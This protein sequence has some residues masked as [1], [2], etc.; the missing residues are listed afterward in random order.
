LNTANSVILC[1]DDEPGNLKLLER[2]LSPSGYLV[3]KANDGQEALDIIAS[4]K[5]DLVLT[6][7][8][9]PGIN[10]FETCRRIKED[11]QYRHIPVVMITAL[12]SKEDRI[13]GIEAGV[14]DFLA[15]PFDHAEVLARVK[16]L[17]K[18]RQ[19]DEM[20]DDSYRN[21]QH[22][23]SF[24]S[25]IMTTFRP[26]EFNLMAQIDSLADQII[27]KDTGDTGKPSTMLVRM[28]NN[29]MLSW[30]LYTHK[31]GKLERSE[32]YLNVPLSNSGEGATYYNNPGSL[33]KFRQLLEAL[34][35][36]G[37]EAS[38]MVCLLSN[39]VSIFTLN[40]GR[41]VTRFDAAVLE[42]L[43]MQTLFFMQLATQIRAS[44]DAFSYTVHALARAAEANDEDTGAHILRVGKYCTILAKKLCLPEEFV[45]S[46]ELQAVLHD[47]GK[48]HIPSEILKKSG[49]L[50][51]KEWEIM[52]LHTVKGAKIIGDHPEFR[53]AKQIAL[54]HHER[55]DGSGY[56]FGY[57]GERIPLEGRIMSIADQY[58]AL[59]NSRV[60]KPALDHDTTVKILTEGDGRTMPQHFDPQVLQAFVDTAH[61]CAEV[62]DSFSED[63]GALNHSGAGFRNFIYEAKLTDT[64][65]ILIIDDDPRLRKTLSDILSANGYKTIVAP[66]GEEGLFLLKNCRTN[67]VLID[68]GLPDMPGIE[69]LGRIKDGHPF[70][71][72][73]ILT[74]NAT[75]E[76]A[77]ESTNSGA[78]SYLLKPYD[79]E[80]LL[81]HIKRAI[82]KQQAEATF[83][84]HS[85]KLEKVNAELK[86]LY[87]VSTVVSKSIDINGILSEILQVLSKLEIYR[88]VNK[89]ALF[90][91]ENKTLRLVSSVNFPAAA[92]EQCKS[93][94][95]GE[96]L[97]GQAES[98]REII[99]SPNDASSSPQTI[100][101]PE[102]TLHRQI[103]IPLKADDKVLGVINLYIEHASRIDEQV[104]NMFSTMGS[105]IGVALEK[106]ILY[107]ETKISSLHDPLTGLGNRRAL[108]LH[109]EKGFAVAKRYEESFSVVM[110]DIDRFKRFNDIHGHQAGDKLLVKVAEILSLETRSS[111][112]VFRYGGEEFL[113]ILA[114]T[115]LANARMVAEKLRGNVE[116]KAG[117]TISLGVAT[118]DESMVN[119]EE[120]VRFAD[121]ALYRAKEKGRNRVE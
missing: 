14:D 73:I 43:A 94:K 61:L 117:I 89:G 86:T 60:Y 100:C 96:C 108:E 92:L 54:S 91:V 103:I 65:S 71:E 31:S 7:V 81:L 116:A 52:K 85:R 114:R 74:G 51:L 102:S 45:N 2:T 13:R 97:C 29:D 34:G 67:V 113:I 99:Y 55:W 93:I 17:L 37:V 49:D 107:E 88:I 84:E 78:F 27:R 62:Y 12:G 109:L 70:V 42:G 35:T 24:G 110:V 30:Y 25:Q 104:R 15:K 36:L 77:I 120:L 9:M 80:Q 112:C 44:D 66:D 40:Y 53:V 115:D 18:T 26:A 33:P 22:L 119:S 69:L 47:V 72:A 90:L 68:L 20:L 21:I 64:P 39:T 32:S 6:D 118:Y 10:G 16:M 3:I 79:I 63:S 111:D 76:S 105:Q 19:L 38:N 59:R 83:V 56:P 28:V 98:T 50:D 11:E 57:S 106:T 41:E 5:V 48:V 58:D 82:E 121:A 8:I 87:D 23:T 75:L 101:N 4:R 46:L 1:V 95:S